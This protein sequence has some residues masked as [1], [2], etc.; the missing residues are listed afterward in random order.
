MT[1]P[2]A[3]DPTP[4]SPRVPCALR[5]GASI[6]LERCLTCAYFKGSTA[7]GNDPRELLYAGPKWWHLLVR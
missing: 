6:D 7:C 2:P 5:G 4:A 1:H 3:A